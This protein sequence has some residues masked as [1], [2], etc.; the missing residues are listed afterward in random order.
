MAHLVEVVGAELQLP[1]EQLPDTGRHPGV[2][3]EA[4]GPAE[5]PL[6]ELHLDGGQ[7]V[8]G[9]LVADHE[10]GI[11]GHPEGV[12]RLDLH[13]REE[14]REVFG[15]HLFQ[16]V[17]PGA[18]G[19]DLEPGQQRRDLHPGE[20]ALA[21][22]P[23]PHHDGEVQRQVGDIG[24]GVAGVDGQGREDGEELLFEPLR[25]ARHGGPPRYPAGRR[26][27]C[28]PRPGPAPGRRRWRP[29]GPPV[30]GPGPGSL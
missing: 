5:A 1:Q 18:V 20:A 17:E 25:G 21:V 28:R 30:R 7:E 12:G 14:H 8:V 15:D 23:V 13:A 11:A 22:A 2:D 29:A 26:A 3:L 10:V 6:A 27:G 24:E 19:R 9:F 16:R 4:H